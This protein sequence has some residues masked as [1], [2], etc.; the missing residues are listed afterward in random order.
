M[1]ILMSVDPLLELSVMT[2]WQEGPE[3][4]D[5]LLYE[6]AADSAESGEDVAGTVEELRTYLAPHLPS[7]PPAGWEFNVPTRR[8]DLAAG[9]RA[10]VEIRLR[11][12]TPGSTVFAVQMKAVDGQEEGLTSA[13]DILVVE[14]PTDPSQ[15][16]LLFVDDDGQGSPRVKGEVSELADWTRALAQRFTL[17]RRQEPG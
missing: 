12:P 2:P 8:L 10:E 3:G 9:E 16:S 13:S 17:G 5:D 7:Q 14:V 1:D 6:L 4:L 11:A 15:A